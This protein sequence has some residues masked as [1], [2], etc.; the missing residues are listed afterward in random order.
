[1]VGKFIRDQEPAITKVPDDKKVLPTMEGQSAGAP[2]ADMEKNPTE[3]DPITGL[4]RDR[5]RN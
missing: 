5:S 1:M 4:F 3:V 2:S